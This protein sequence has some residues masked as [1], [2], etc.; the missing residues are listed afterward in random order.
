MN[1][2]IETSDPPSV[3]EEVKLKAQELRC[4]SA[5]LLR[6]NTLEHL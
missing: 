6:L 1:I 5:R 2:E 3:A 4:D